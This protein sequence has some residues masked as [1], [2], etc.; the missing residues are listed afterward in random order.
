MKRYQVTISGMR[1]MHCVGNVKKALSAL[2]GATAA[3]VSLDP[4]AAV[5][6]GSVSAEAIRGAVE[7]L[8]F[9]VQRIEEM[10]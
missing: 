6:E 8:G 9:S 1:C 4:G 7:A 5:V 2:E 3:E 10:Q